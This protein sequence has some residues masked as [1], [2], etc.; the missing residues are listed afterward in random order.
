M[1]KKIDNIKYNL[2]NYGHNFCNFDNIYFENLWFT[3]KIHFS[4]STFLS[5]VINFTQSELKECSHFG[6]KFSDRFF[7]NFSPMYR[8]QNHFLYRLFF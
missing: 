3:S 6:L 7:L 2:Q 1:G 5:T 4:D 8:P